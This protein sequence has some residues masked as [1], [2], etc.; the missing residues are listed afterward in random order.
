MTAPASLVEPPMEEEFVRLAMECVAAGFV[1][2]KPD[3]AIADLHRWHREQVERARA[4]VGRACTD[5]LDRLLRESPPECCEPFTTARDC[6]LLMLTNPELH[7]AL[8]SPPAREGEGVLDE[9]AQ[10]I[11]QPSSDEV[12]RA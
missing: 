8:S 4:E 2:C 11:K 3:V 1:H 5:E 7:A 10:P 9:S 6:V 12:P